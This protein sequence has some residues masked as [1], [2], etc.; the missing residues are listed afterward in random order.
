MSSWFSIFIREK[1]FESD[2]SYNSISGQS[3]RKLI[4]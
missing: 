1:V 4:N 2:I 3:I